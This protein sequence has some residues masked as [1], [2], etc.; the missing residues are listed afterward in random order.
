MTTDIPSPGR[1][2]I[3]GGGTAGWPSAAILF[4]LPGVTLVKSRDIGIMD[5]G[6]GLFPNVASASGAIIAHLP[7]HCALLDQ[8]CARQPSARV[9]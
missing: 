6:V 4:R 8:M 2:V 7:D 5:V 1:I 9:S 3:P